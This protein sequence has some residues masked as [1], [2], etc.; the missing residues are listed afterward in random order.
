MLCT[1]A[2]KI[3]LY[4]NRK[5]DTQTQAHYLYE[6]KNKLIVI[7]S[8]I[9][10]LI[11]L[12]NIF[13]PIHNL[14]SVIIPLDMYYLN[15]EIQKGLHAMSENTNG[16]FIKYKNI[17]TTKVNTIKNKLEYL[18]ELVC[19]YFAKKREFPHDKNEYH[20]NLENI[21]LK[22]EEITN[23]IDKHYKPDN[24][25]LQDIMTQTLDNI[26]YNN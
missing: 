18:A 8:I 20:I 21:H 19:E 2:Y 17:N 12:I 13:T 9:Y 10:A 16:N 6:N 1:L 11:L 25:K 3:S 14:L 26:H 5:N 23:K 7:G 4:Y 24:M 22:A 15:E